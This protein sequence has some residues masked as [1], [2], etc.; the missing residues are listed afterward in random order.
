M[1]GK[2][3]KE[4]MVYIPA[5]NTGHLLKR[6]VEEIPK[7]IANKVILVDNV[8]TDD[9]VEVARSLGIFVIEHE[10]NKGY[11]GSQKSGYRYFL[12][13]GGDLVVMLHSDYQYDPNYIPELIAPILD[14]E[15]DIVLGSRVLGGQ[16]LK[17]GMP[18]W[19]FFFNRLLTHMKNMII[20]AN[21]VE[22]DT[23]FRAFSRELLESIPFE[24][25]SDNFLFDTEILFQVHHFGFKLKEI[26]IPTR[27]SEDSS[28]MTFGQGVIYGIGVFKALLIYILHTLKIRRSPQYLPKPPANDH[29][30]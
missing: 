10:V 9:T 2:E 11:G 24:E 25:N 27:Y 14:D 29:I 5:R 6:T 28:M 15:A 7:G 26:P 4:V 22:Y 21:I 19:K 30:P 13:T 16:A 23:G 17:G 18:L 12:E 20:G 3:T 1:S 8:S